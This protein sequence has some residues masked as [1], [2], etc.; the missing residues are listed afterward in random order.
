M[1]ELP[2]NNFKH[3]LRAGRIQK[4]LWLGLA[5]SYVAELLAST[6]F[7]WLLIDAEHGPNDLRQVLAQLQAIAP[8]PTHP[9]V[10][11]VEGNV[12]LIKQYLDIG[13]QTLLIPMIETAEQ[14]AHM[15]AATRYP[16]HGIR[17]VGSA[18]ARAS[19]WNQVT[20]YLHR[21]EQEICVLL[22]VESVKAI[23]NLAA[24]AAVEG[25][26]G[27]FFGPAD[28]S[29]SMGYLGNPG[30]APVQKAIEEGIAVVRK[31]GKAA[32]I[33]S[34]DRTLARK[35]I[36]L[37]AQF[38]AVGVDTTLLVRAASELAAYFSTDDESTNQSV[39]PGSVY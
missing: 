17:G 4:G 26:D 29:G 15:V 16:P 13:A 20:D 21:A 1:A 39:P 24:I 10:R 27:V 38:V 36:D 31:A 34:A 8:Y 5:D 30:A 7:D 6:G 14:A 9:V 25:V 3:A 11:P 35:Y 12:A 23:S 22:Q 37:G 28:L 2:R 32:G 19:R 18:L 33:L